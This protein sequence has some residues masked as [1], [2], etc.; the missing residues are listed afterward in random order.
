MGWC[1]IADGAITAISACWKSR[2][3]EQFAA[4]DHCV[5]TKTTISPYISRVYPSCFFLDK[6]SCCIVELLGRYR[7]PPS[8]LG[9]GT[10]VRASWFE[11][12][13]PCPP[14]S[15][16]HLPAG[17]DDFQEHICQTLISIKNKTACLISPYWFLSENYHVNYNSSKTWQINKLWLLKTL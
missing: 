13:L 9:A 2:A 11:T 8:Q 4:V 10:P 3:S 17:R 15:I 14:N 6:S 12:W 1:E 7:T 16:L 5:L